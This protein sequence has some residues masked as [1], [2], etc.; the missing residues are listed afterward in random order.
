MLVTNVPPALPLK[1]KC[2]LQHIVTSSASPP[3]LTSELPADG[4]VLLGIT[5]MEGSPPP[6]SVELWAVI[7][8]QQS[9]SSCLRPTGRHETW[10]ECP[11]HQLKTGNR[12]WW[13][14]IPVIWTVELDFGVNMWAWIHPA[15]YQQPVLLKVWWVSVEPSSM[16]TV[17]HL[18]AVSAE[19]RQARRQKRSKPG[20]QRTC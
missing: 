20:L 19:L 8:E 16:T 13:L 15:L 6:A 4:G 18:T 12:G 5:A 9:L 14:W 17:W 10:L 7:D 3:A 1:G 2:T 11:S